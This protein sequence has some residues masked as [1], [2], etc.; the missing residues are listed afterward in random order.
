MSVLIW[1]FTF[2]FVSTDVSHY[3]VYHDNILKYERQ[4]KQPTCLVMMLKLQDKLCMRERERGGARRRVSA[5]LSKTTIVRCRKIK[6]T[7]FSLDAYM[8]RKEVE[9]YRKA[10]CQASC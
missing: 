4:N 1:Y 7:L 3:A 9:E 2:I 10:T 8:H 6:E 5:S